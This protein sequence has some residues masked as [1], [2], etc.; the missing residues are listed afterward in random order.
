MKAKYEVWNGES[1]GNL[2]I[3]YYVYEK[4]AK[5]KFAQLRQQG[6]D[7]ATIGRLK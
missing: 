5:K 7:K 4:S 1:Q 3:Y 2:M 6:F